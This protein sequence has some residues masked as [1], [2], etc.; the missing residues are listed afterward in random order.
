MTMKTLLATA[1]ISL[2]FTG[3]AI[4]Q[5]TPANGTMDTTTTTNS[6]GTNDGSMAN[7][8]GKMMH[9]RHHRHHRHHH[10]HHYHHMMM[11]KDAGMGGTGAMSNGNTG[12][13]SNGNTGGAMGNGA[14][15]PQ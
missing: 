3:V 13:M 6:S 1:A 14:T 11:H 15:T 9:H 7:G 10:H 5:P 4:A 2:V 8:S 12:G